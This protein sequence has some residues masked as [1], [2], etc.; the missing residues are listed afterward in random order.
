MNNVKK[1]ILSIGLIAITS[2]IYL[3]LFTHDFMIS[4]GIITFFI[5]AYFYKDLNKILTGIMSG[6]MVCLLRVLVSLVDKGSFIE[7]IVSF[8]PEIFFY[9]VIGISI[10]LFIKVDFF[11]DLDKMFFT[12]LITDILANGTEMI[13]RSK[14]ELIV[15]DYNI[16]GTLMAVAISRA[17]IIWLVLNG[18]KYYKI[19][20]LNKE[21]AEKYKEFLMISSG[22]KAEMYLMERNMEYIEKSMEEAY[23]LYEKIHNK[24]EIDT[25][26]KDAISI[27]KNIHEIKK[28]YSMALSGVK[29]VTEIGASNEDMY[30]YDILN[31]LNEG[32]NNL[33]R[34]R[35]LNVKVEF[36]KGDNFLTS[37]HYY[38]ISVFRNL[39]INALDAVKDNSEN[40]YIEFTHEFYEGMD[41]FKIIDNGIGIVEEDLKYLFSPGFSTKI[42]YKTGD[43]NRG[44]GLSITQD[45]VELK[46][47][48]TIKV[49]SELNKGTIFKIEIPR[50]VLEVEK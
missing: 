39:L 16:F 12:A 50:E 19:L 22:L 44:L 25:W 43:I 42:D 8:S 23:N 41:I 17:L 27:A 5:I 37:Q 9:I 32:I 24:T 15:L 33:I 48:G 34:E 2:Q 29:R 7:G 45:I 11:R 35:N 26:E 40:G 38:L 18:L 36:D 4:A 10:N 1:H 47:K 30:F 6:I 49:Y 28:D 3:A 31:I 46:L 13:I 21:N 14:M 20:L